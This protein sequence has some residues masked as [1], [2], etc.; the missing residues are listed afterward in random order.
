MKW[1]TW[2]VCL[3][4]GRYEMNSKRRIAAGNRV[5]GAL[6]TL[7]RRRNV[8]APARLAVHNAVL[9]CCS[10][11]VAVLWRCDLFVV[12]VRSVWLIESAMKRYT[13]WQVLVE[14]SRWE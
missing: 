5:N 13:E 14:M 8:S 12:S 6:A 7:M 9:Y 10:C 1:Y 11:R 4:D 3:V 2:E